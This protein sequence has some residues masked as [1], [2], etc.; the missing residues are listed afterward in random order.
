MCLEELLLSRSDVVDKCR[1]TDTNR[2]TTIQN[3]QDAID[4]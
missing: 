2:T 4:R 3:E 1:T